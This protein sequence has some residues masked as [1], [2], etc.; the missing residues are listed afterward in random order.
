ME[1]VHLKIK[2]V[3]SRITN[4]VLQQSPENYIQYPLINHNG[5]EYENEYIHMCV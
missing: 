1:Y 4:K 5:Q 2:N 3:Y